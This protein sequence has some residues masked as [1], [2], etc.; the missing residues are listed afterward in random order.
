M[1]RLSR[2]ES[3]A[4]TREKLLATAKESFLREGY[5][6]TSLEKIADAAGYSKGAVYSNFRNKDELCLAVID[7]VRAERAASLGEAVSGL[8]S[9]GERIAA[10]QRWAERNIGDRAWTALEVE[11]AVHAARDP[12][13]SRELTRRDK[14][15]RDTV[16]SLVTGHASELG[17]ALPMPAE[18]VAIA[19]LSL[20][21]G[22]GVQRA[23][24]PSVP[25]RALPELLRL[26]SGDAGRSNT[27]KPRS[28]KR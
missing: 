21:I 18:D 15:V 12:A 5:A 19:L 13:L 10:F 23:L 9:L 26:L 4:R 2:A 11:F 20:G 3:Q 7:A 14:V 25:V 17:I 22:L 8:T 16:V 1:P 24:D 27:A 28:A 6:A